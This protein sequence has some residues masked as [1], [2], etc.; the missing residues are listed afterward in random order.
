M[1]D[2][3]TKSSVTQGHGSFPPTGFTSASSTLFVEGEGVLC[4]GDSIIPHTDGEHV[5][6]GSITKGSSV[7]V[8]DGKPV[9]YVGCNISCG[10][11]IATGKSVLDVA[12]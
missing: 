7:L 4:V 8:V 2:V 10:D 11:K 5:H 9:A 12:P 6:G 1:P 3:A